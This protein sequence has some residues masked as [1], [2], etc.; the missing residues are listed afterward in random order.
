MHGIAPTT[1]LLA[2]LWRHRCTTPRSAWRSTGHIGHPLR[3]RAGLLQLAYLSWSQ[4]G[5]RLIPRILANT[6]HLLHELSELP[7]ASQSGTAFGSTTSRT[8]TRCAAACRSATRFHLS[9]H[10]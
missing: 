8:T 9:F 5:L 3:A 1:L 4:H 10:L 7:S 2:F 6:L